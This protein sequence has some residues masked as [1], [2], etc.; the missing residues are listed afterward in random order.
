[1]KLYLKGAIHIENW[2]KTLINNPDPEIR[3]KKVII[4]YNI[5]IVNI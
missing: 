4:L 2:P 5:I 1:M 3:I